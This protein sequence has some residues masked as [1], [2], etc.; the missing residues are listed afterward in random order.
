MENEQ[1]KQNTNPD[2]NYVENIIFVFKY[3][4]FTQKHLLGLREL[5]SHTQTQIQREFYNLSLIFRRCEMRNINFPS[6]SH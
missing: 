4:F 3:F 5:H 6:F 1:Q 2:Q